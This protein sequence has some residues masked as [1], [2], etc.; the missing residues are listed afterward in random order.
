MA[1]FDPATTQLEVSLTVDPLNVA[2]NFRIVLV[3]NDGPNTGEEYQF[4]FDLTSLIPGQPA[5]I[6]QSLINPGPAIVK[7]SAAKRMET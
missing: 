2:S 6:S 3:D 7:L 1:D 5:V 4:Y